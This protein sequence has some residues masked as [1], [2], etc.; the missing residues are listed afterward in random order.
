MGLTKPIELN[1]LS[2]QGTFMYLK[3]IIRGEISMEEAHRLGEELASVYLNGKYEYVIATHIDKEHIHNHIIFNSVSFVTYKKYHEKN[4][5]LRNLRKIS[6]QICKENGYSV[7]E[8]PSGV[9]GKGRYEYEQDQRGRSWKSK[10]K[11]EID[12]AILDAN[13]W[14]EF[15]GIMESKGY[16]IKEGKHISFRAKDQER[17]CRAKTIGDFYTEESIRDRIDR[18]EYYR[19]VEQESKEQKKQE[20]R[21]D[22]TNHKKQVWVDKNKIN[23]IA[24]IKNNIKAQKYG[25]YRYKMGISNLQEMSKTLNFLTLNHLE[26]TEQL[27]NKIEAMKSEHSIARG[28]IKMMESKM[29]TLS[30]KTKYVMQFKKYYAVY[31]QARKEKPGSTYLKEHEGELIMFEIAKKYVTTNKINVKDTNVKELLS[32]YKKMQEER[33]ALYVTYKDLKAQLK[34]LDNIRKNIETM[35]GKE[36]RREATRE[37]KKEL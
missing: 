19:N 26:S 4:N 15:L 5:E 22:K 13:T 20:S 7:I 28:K 16:E 32:Q 25:G 1:L 23:L 27:L 8:N 12:A 10:L 37:E 21:K 2:D 31:L 34:D 14:E 24:D 11:E 9:R 33:S 35:T 36:V 30:E 3:N 18:K 6:D 29:S 17:F